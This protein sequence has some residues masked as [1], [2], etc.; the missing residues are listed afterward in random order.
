[1]KRRKY[2]K[3]TIIKCILI[4]IS[5]ICGTILATMVYYHN[6]VIGKYSIIV[7]LRDILPIGIIIG[8]I[9]AFIFFII[10]CLYIFIKTKKNKNI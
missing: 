2:I 6:D 3:A 9:F 7:L 5:C 4:F 8:A 1:M 10:I